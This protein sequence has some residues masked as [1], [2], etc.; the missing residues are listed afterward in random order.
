MRR[1]LL[2]EATEQPL[3]RLVPRNE[4][5]GMELHRD[6]ERVVRVLEPLDHAVRRSSHDLE[7][8]RHV[9]YRLMME[10][11]HPHV[12]RAEQIGQPGVADD[13]DLVGDGVAR[14]ESMDE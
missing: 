10:A 11:V 1:R 3:T 2:D 12:G 4:L 5:L 13:V 7:W 9:A 14:L 8:C 6:G